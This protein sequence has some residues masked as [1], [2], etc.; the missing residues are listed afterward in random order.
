MRLTVLGTGAWGTALALSLS[1]F[2]SVTLWGRDPDQ[3]QALRLTRENR[4]YLPGHALPPSLQLSSHLP[5]ALQDADLALL[6]VPVAA[7]E[8]ILSAL[9]TLS[10]HLPFLWACK[11]VEQGTR[12]LP[13]QIVHAHPTLQGPHGVLSGPSF[14]T[15]IAAGLP[16]ALTLASSNETFAQNTARLLHHPHLRLY[17]STDLVGVEIA[18]ALKNVMA[19]ASGLSDGLGLGLNARAALI[20]R[21]LAEITR[22]GMV[23][24]GRRA[25]FMGL[26][27]LGDLILTCTTALSRNYQVGQG[28][29]QGHQLGPLL[30]GLGHVAEGVPTALAALQLAQAHGVEMPITATVQEVLSGALNVQDAVIQLLARD[31]RAE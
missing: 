1:G 11:G 5:S 26:T 18:G 23:L 9:A 27:G 17:S 22:L 19:I 8:E 13:H 30:T 20:T 21:G 4:R 24:G 31:P 6:V 2:H 28:L 12:R 25:T 14:A 7:L 3:V 10:P 15:E 29:A 16:A